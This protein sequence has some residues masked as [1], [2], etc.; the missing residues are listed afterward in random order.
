[1]W[2]RTGDAWSAREQEIRDS[3]WGSNP[4][5]RGE[6]WE[7]WS[8]A[9]IGG[10][11]LGGV[12]DFTVLGQTFTPNLR[13]DTDWRGFQAGAD[14]LHG[15]WLWGLTGGFL[16]QN[17][18]FH[19]DRNSLDMTG[20]NFGGYGG[21]TSGHFFLNGLVKGDWFEVKSNM[22]T[23]PAYET[24]NGN[25][26]GAKAETGFRIGG[27]GLYFEPVADISWTSTHLDNAGFQNVS[28]TFS[29]GDSST[30][31]GSIGAR[32][33]AQWGSILP[34]IG[35]YAV[36]EWDSNAKVTMVTGSG[37][38]SCISIDD[39]RPGSY[40]KADLG[41]TTTSW[42]GLEGFVKVEDEFGSHVD[43]FIGRLGV[44]W[45]W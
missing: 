15:N 13:T 9:Q 35:I 4:G 14:T 18:I 42:N 23:V 5:T 31:R 11:R 25:D 26:W 41:F 44:R 12:Q 20:W 40:G 37:C 32:A 34:Y 28:T 29:F 22:P 27:A 3:M 33:G 19:A 17:T 36:D 2:R 8:Q 1:F 38:P 30:T 16:E 21:F 39:V 10:E 6:G 45:R 43:G 24:F 7:L